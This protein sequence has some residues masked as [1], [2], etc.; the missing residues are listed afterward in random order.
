[1]VLIADPDTAY[2]DP[3]RARKTLVI[4]CFVADPVTGESYSP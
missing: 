2:I 3:F 4:H 1:M